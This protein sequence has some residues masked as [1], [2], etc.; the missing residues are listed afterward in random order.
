[1]ISKIKESMTALN[2]TI[3]V[4]IVMNFKIVLHVQSIEKLLL[5]VVVTPNII[6]VYKIK[7]VINVD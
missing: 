2:V 4:M 7:S 1:M 3:N 5:I 6:S